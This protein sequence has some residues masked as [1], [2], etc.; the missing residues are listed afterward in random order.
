MTYFLP[1]FLLGESIVGFILGMYLQEV[2]WE[3][4]ARWTARQARRRL[5][6]WRPPV[7]SRR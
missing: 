7:G 2:W 3:I 4:R 6:N 5:K 1:L